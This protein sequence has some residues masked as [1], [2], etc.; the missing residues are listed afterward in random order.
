MKGPKNREYVKRET[1]LRQQSKEGK[2]KHESG[3]MI[4]SMDSPKMPVFRRLAP[5]VKQMMVVMPVKD[6]DFK[7]ALLDRFLVCALRDGLEVVW[8]INKTDL[9]GP[10]EEK[11]LSEMTTLYQSLGLKTIRSCTLNNQGLEEVRKC[12]SEYPTLM[13]GQS[14]VGK[15]SLINA[16]VGQTLQ[17]TGEMSSSSGKGRHTTVQ[18]TSIQIPGGG[19]VWDLPGIK[20][21]KLWDV[22]KEELKDHFPEFREFSCKFGDCLH[23]GETGCGLPQA[24]ADGLVHEGRVRSYLGMLEEA[25]DF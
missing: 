15:S 20:Y 4:R 12:V 3:D 2:R 11:L 10:E 9:I 8:V 16:L 5:Q 21:L 22:G 18:A 14:G 7:Q 19:T 24:L 13:V 23:Q 17:K 6:P 1:F 25:H